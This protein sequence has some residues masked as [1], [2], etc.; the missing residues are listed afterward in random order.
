MVKILTN[1]PRRADQ[2]PR[3]PTGLLPRPSQEPPPVEAILGADIPYLDAS[4]EELVRV[5][6]INPPE[7]VREASVRHGAPGPAH[8]PEGATVVCSTYV[9]HKPFGEAT[10]PG[11]LAERRQQAGQ[12]GL[13]GGLAAGHG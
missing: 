13:R 5:G 10:V 9:A 7:V 8:I 6:N 12:D 1:A 3:R 2:A 11:E 4:I